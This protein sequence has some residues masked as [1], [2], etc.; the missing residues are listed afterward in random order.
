MNYVEA[1]RGFSDAMGLV[2]QAKRIQVGALNRQDFSLDE[3]AWVRREAYR[4]AG[5]PVLSTGLVEA[6]ASEDGSAEALMQHTIDGDSLAAPAPNRRL[7]GPHQEQLERMAG[8]AFF[9]L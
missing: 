4:A 6:I 9:G 3:Y 7:I 5:I 2:L 1:L 8:L